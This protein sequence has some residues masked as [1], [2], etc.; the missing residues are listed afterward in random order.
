MA[1]NTYG[2]FAEGFQQGFGL[3]EGA[4]QRR[5]QREKMQLDEDFRREQ[6]DFQKEQ[7]QDLQAYREKDLG[8]KELTAE[9]T[10]NLKVLQSEIAKSQAATNE[11]K[12]ETA[13]L[14]QQQLTD[15]NSLASQK[16]QAE[17]A[18]LKSET[19]QRNL[20]TKT[21]ANNNS[22]F[23]NAVILNKLYEISTRTKNSPL[24][25][26]ELAE[27]AKGVNALTGGGRFDLG[28][29]LNPATEDSMREIQNFVQNLADGSNPE[30]TPQVVGAFDDML[31]IGKS[32]A[33]GRVLD[34]SFINAPDWMKDGKH[35]VVSQGLH[36]VGSYD[37]KK[38]SGTLYVMV[39]NQ[40]SGEVY[41]Y[42]P[43]LTSNRSNASNQPLNLTFNEAMQATAG[44]A[45][46]IRS[47]APELEQHAKQAKIKE[48]FGDRKGNSGVDK[49]NAAVDRRLEEVRRG[50][51]SGA[52]PSSLA[53]MPNMEG[54][55]VS[56]KLDYAATDENRRKIEHEILYGPQ[57]KKQDNVR[58]NEW[59]QETSQ[60]LN[61]APLPNGFK[62]NLGGIIK[63][64]WTPQNVSILQGYYDSDGN[65]SDEKGLIQALQKLNFL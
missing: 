53:F 46:M 48:M 11:T 57:N 10:A 44:T 61:N 34:E 43:P 9:Q 38:F 29:I 55:T 5:A 27:Y 36:E 14:E 63:G 18:K 47:V 22:E 56:E 20:E 17:L 59:F 65:I 41:P 4:A 40:E 37:G 52:S 24:G 8:I 6:L 62:T 50:I 32:A 7:Q 1:L 19:E 23:D 12:A 21:T 28:F 60:A 51:Q 3:M 58:V 15:P 16:K 2:G 30:M 39:Q 64:Q 13:L 42:F 31:G 45:H 35:K 54:A 26:S 49:F 33:V 25:E